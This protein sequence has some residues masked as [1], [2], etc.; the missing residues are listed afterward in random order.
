VEK[1]NYLITEFQ[2]PEF[3]LLVCIVRNGSVQND[4][5]RIGNLI[6]EKINWE[7]L[8]ELANYHGVIPLLY[9]TL[10]ELDP[11]IIP[12]KIFQSLQTFYMTNTQRNIALL[13]EMLNLIKRLE[14]QDIAVI[15]FKGPLLSTILYHDHSIRHAGD[16]DFLV[17]PDDVLAAVKILDDSGYGLAIPLSQNQLSAVLNISPNIALDFFHKRSKTRVDLHWRFYSN[18]HVNK[19]AADMVWVNIEP[20][21]FNDMD[22]KTLSPEMLLL[23]HCLHGF[24]H[25][26]ECLIWIWELS[27]IIEKY[28]DLDW[29]W[30]IKESN[31]F[32]S[33]ESLL[34][35]MYLVNRVIG[36]PLPKPINKR[37]SHRPDIPQAVSKGWLEPTRFEIHT[38]HKIK[39][40]SLYPRFRIRG[41]TMNTIKNLIKAS[42][43]PNIL[44]VSAV[45]L[46]PSL[47]PLY[48]IIKPFRLS[49][50]YLK[51]LISATSSGNFVR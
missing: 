30:I 13:A 15:P 42:F 5:S 28:L 9:L 46:P 50:K 20:F 45:D 49:K 33:E 34:I 23:F 11:E 32:G 16:L 48:Y 6:Q 17:K 14:E 10:K 2:N 12:Q 44:D 41:N 35:G 1:Q 51:K 18:Y 4:T 31:G 40:N 25:N 43:T 47:Y 3:E 36:T 21:F 38:V 24:N 8:L 37:I 29:E 22:I 27:K 26:W 39:M 19:T 7:Y